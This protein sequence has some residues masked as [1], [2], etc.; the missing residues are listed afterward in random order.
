MNPYILSILIALVFLAV[1]FVVGKTITALKLKNTS[2]GLNASLE[3]QKIAMEEKERLIKRMQEDL[4]LIR[5]EKEQLTIDFT[6]KDSELKNTNQKLVENK[7]EVEKLQEKFTKEFKVL[8]NE[9]LESNSSKITKQN[10]ENLETILN[11]LQEK[12]KTFEKKVEDTHKDSID[13]HAALRQQI[14]GLKE[15]NEQMSKEAINLTKALKGDSKVQGD[16]GETQLEVLLE[17]ANLSK[18]IHYTTQGGYRDKEGTLKKPDFVI[19]LPDNRHLIVDA[20]VSL[21]DYERYF[22]EEDDALKQQHL[23]KHIESLRKHFKGLGEKKYSDLY[24]INSPDYVLM[25]V[26]I[27]PA[28]MLA[29]HESK[30]LYLEAL[31]KNVVLVSTSTLLATLSTVSSMWRQENQKKNVLEIAEQAG[32]LYDQFVNLTDDFIKVGNQLKT[33]QG[34][35]DSSMKK[36][37]GKGNLIRKVERIKELGAKANK[38]I[39]KNLLDR[40]SESES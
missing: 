13:R 2:A 20:K 24:E 9:I 11:P 5:N 26:P 32:R 1:G 38:N 39:N 10:K 27:E 6:R 18:E 14:V 23:K 15:L 35:Y 28:L 8:A 29:L 31:D 3:S 25:F 4:E 36:L 40:A 17:K 21:V 12:I 34:S 19:N 7:Q 30:N 33:V 16:W 37:T 22:S